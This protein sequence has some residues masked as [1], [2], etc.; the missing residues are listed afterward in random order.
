MCGFSPREF[1]FCWTFTLLKL[2]RGTSFAGR[3]CLPPGEW[4]WPCS[5][6][7][8]DNKRKHPRP[9]SYKDSPTVNTKLSVSQ[10]WPGSTC[11]APEAAPPYFSATCPA[12][13]LYTCPETEARLPSSE[14]RPKP[15]LLTNEAL[16]NA[17]HVRRFPFVTSS[18]RNVLSTSHSIASHWR[19]AVLPGRDWLRRSM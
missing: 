7:L 13:I 14:C 18:P 16:E 15:C 17:A 19:R 12:S 4:A 6:P 3:R 9:S 10:S 11:W 2:F 8:K 5:W 1:L